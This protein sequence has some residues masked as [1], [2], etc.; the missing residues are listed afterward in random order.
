MNYKEQAYQRQANIMIDQLKKRNMEAIYC[1]KKEQ[2]VASALHIMEDRATISWGGS[3]TLYESGLIHALYHSEHELLDIDKAFSEEESQKIERAVLNCDYYLM[4]SNAITRDGQL[5][6]IDG[7]G[8]RVAALIHGPKQVL[9]LV[10]M[11]KVV[12]DVNAAIERVQAVAAPANAI[13]LGEDVPCAKTGICGNCL[14]SDCMCSQIVITRM[15]KQEG[16]IKV[17]LIGEE[18]GY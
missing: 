9:I 15:S 8:N 6:N 16:R 5:V 7:H 14:V 3:Q 1:A 17:I 4:S 12:P 13:R 2:A 11:N 18:L 10:S